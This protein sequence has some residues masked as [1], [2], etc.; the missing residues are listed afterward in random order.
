MGAHTYLFTFWLPIRIYNCSQH[1]Q[2]LLSCK[3][4]DHT[5]CCN[6]SEPPVIL[7]ICTFFTVTVLQVI[8]H[9]L[10]HLLSHY[11]KP[12]RTDRNVY[13]AKQIFMHKVNTFFLNTQ[14]IAISFFSTKRNIPHKSSMQIEMITSQ[15]KNKTKSGSSKPIQTIFSNKYLKHFFKLDI[16]PLNRFI[17]LKEIHLRNMHSYK[18][19][20]FNRNK[21]CS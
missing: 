16:F 21:T 14:R 10:W 9:P 7:E 18:M 4:C 2:L 11:D 15:K 13:T 5:Q 6:V 3:R 1:I 8:Y 20:L 17:F 19:N 12:N